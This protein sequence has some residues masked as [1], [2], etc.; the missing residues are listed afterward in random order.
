MPA[1]DGVEL[2][3]MIRQQPWGQSVKLVALTGLGLQTERERTGA[4]Q[5]DERLTKPA[6]PNDLLRAVATLRH[7]TPPAETEVLPAFAEKLSSPP[8]PCRIEHF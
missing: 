4:A 6:D 1:P 7:P 2:A 5:F 8:S 3:R